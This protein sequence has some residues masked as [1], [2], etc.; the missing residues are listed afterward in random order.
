M[1]ILSLAKDI[2]FPQNKV[3]HDR[4]GVTL[5][6][7]CPGATRT[8]IIGHENVIDKFLFPEMLNQV[9]EISKKMMLQE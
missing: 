9:R 2:E 5:I 7:V 6:V 8:P 4:T 3:F 1:F